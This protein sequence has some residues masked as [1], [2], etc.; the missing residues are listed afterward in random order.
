MVSYLWRHLDSVDI[1][2]PQFAGT[3]PAFR[4][5]DSVDYFDFTGTWQATEEISVSIS[6]YNVFG[7]EP[8]VVGNEAGTTSSNSGNTFPSMYDTLGTVFP[9][10]IHLRI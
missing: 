2:A 8:P 3:F 4:F 10:G 6:A 1:E 9:A 7:E 5:I